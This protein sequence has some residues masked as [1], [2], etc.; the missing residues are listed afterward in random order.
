MAP[1]LEAPSH[2]TG[3]SPGLVLVFAVACGLAV[4]NLYYAQPVLDTIAKSFHTSSATAG[5]VVTL[6]QIGYAI[7]LALLVP[8]GDLVSRRRL[9]P[10]V[11]TVTTGGLIVSALAPSIGVLIA[12][13]LVV[14]AGSVVAQVLIPMAASLASAEHRG[15]VVGTVMSGLLIGILLARTVSGVVAGATSWRA[16]YVMAAVLTAGM[17]IVLGRVLP[18]GTGAAEDRLRHAATRARPPS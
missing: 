1:S 14:G 4:A 12:V 6:S 2:R 13:A 7:G 18:D 9:V 16:V 10:L 15:R 3:L 8:L 11:L 5:L 17:A